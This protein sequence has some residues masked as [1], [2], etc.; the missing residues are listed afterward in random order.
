MCAGSWTTG[1]GIVT[2][3]W[4]AFVRAIMHGRDGYDAS[5]VTAAMSDAGASDVRS[6]LATGNVTF[7]A[8]DTRLDVII[9]AADATID[10]SVRDGDH[11]LFVRTLE[12]VRLLLEM[13]VFADAPF[14]APERLVS[15]AEASLPHDLR[16]PI[17][18]PRG[19]SSTF[20]ATD[21]EL[22]SVVRDVDGRRSA[23]GGRLEALLGRPL[24]TRAVST[25]E[26]L[27]RRAE[28]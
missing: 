11:R 8:A 4:V 26:L 10:A 28:E 20:A 6:H 17:V 3:T 23:P 7:V 9:A 14:D 22:F 18:S 1:D 21:R 27:V 16:L 25:L 19:D 15:F 5:A 13:E 24:T 12:H 2:T